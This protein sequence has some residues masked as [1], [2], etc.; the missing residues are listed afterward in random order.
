MSSEWRK[1]GP[2]TPLER[3][4]ATCKFLSHKRRLHFIF[5]QVLT[6]HCSLSFRVLSH[7]LANPSE[8]SVTSKSGGNKRKAASKSTKTKKAKK[9]KDPNR[10]KR[11]L[12]A[13]MNFSKAMRPT[14]LA[15]NPGILF[16]EVGGKIAE[17]WRLLNDEEKAEHKSAPVEEEEEAAAAAEEPEEEEVEEEEEEEEAEEEA[18]EESGEAAAGDE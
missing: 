12:S 15:E 4:S 8:G 17:K 6:V 14:V 7:S 10:K 2:G 9:A 11:P 13:Y 16:A 18:E 1:A 3:A 5:V